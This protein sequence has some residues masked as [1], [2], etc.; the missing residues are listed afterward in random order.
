VVKKG[1][2]PLACMRNHVASRS[3]EVIVPLYSAW[4]TDSIPTTVDSFGPPHY[5]KDRKLLDGFQEE[6]QN[7]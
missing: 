2:G 1:T 5:K 7:R 6:Q 3:R 4:C